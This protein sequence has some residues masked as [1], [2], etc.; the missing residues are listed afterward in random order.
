MAAAGAA[1]APAPR[2]S[3][4]RCPCAAEIEHPRRRRSSPTPC[5][6]RRAVHHSPCQVFA[7]ISMAWRFEPASGIARHGEEAPHPLAGIRVVRRDVAACAVVGAAVADDDAAI[8]HARRAGDRIGPAL[9]RWSARST[10]WPVA[11]SS[12]MSRPSIV[13]MMILPF[14]A[15]RAAADHIA[16]RDPGRAR[17]STCRIVAPQLLAARRRP[18][19]M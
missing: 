17:D 10:G 9:R 19:R 8:D 16:A 7:A 3:R 15:A 14:Q 5:R 11:A 6:R 12:A 2:A 1:L 13:A 4:C 18:A